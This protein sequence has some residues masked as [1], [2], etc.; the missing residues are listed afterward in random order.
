M[1]SAELIQSVDILD[2]ISQYTEFK[3]RNGEY[4]ALSPLTD[5]VTPSFSVNADRNC[6]YDFSSG[7]SGNIISFIRAY[8]KCSVST[9]FKIL[10]DYAGVSD[11]EESP[12]TEKMEATRIAMKFAPKQKPERVQTASILD[13]HYMDMYDHGLKWLVPWINEGISEPSLRKFNVCYDAFSNRIVFPIRDMEGHIINVSGRT[14]D[15]LYKERKLR[16]YTYFKPLGALDTLYGFA[17]NREA[18]LAKKEV[19]IF[20]GAKSVMKADS[21]GIYNT[22]A[23]LTSHLNENQLKRLIK[24]GVTTVFAFDKE[25]EPWRDR[26]IQRLTQFVPVKYIRDNLDLLDDKMAPVDAGPELF[27]TLYERRIAMRYAL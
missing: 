16:K 3:Y 11:L 18:I 4:W 19:I 14:L 22:C 8:N 6:F 10:S 12:K 7:C 21:W 1:T 23:V 24:L 2:Y 25:V 15:P 17:E 26:N 20:E 5:E 13:E 9:A 27:K